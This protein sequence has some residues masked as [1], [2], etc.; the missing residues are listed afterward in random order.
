MLRTMEKD[1]WIKGRDERAGARRRF[2]RITEKGR[3]A[4]KEIRARL[5]ELFEEAG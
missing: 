2:Y 5:R 3:A 4:L 1:G